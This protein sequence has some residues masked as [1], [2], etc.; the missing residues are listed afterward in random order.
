MITIRYYEVYY[1]DNSSEKIYRYEDLVACKRSNK[2][3]KVIKEYT[4]TTKGWI[5]KTL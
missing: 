4:L 3:I 5:T 2:K 1:A